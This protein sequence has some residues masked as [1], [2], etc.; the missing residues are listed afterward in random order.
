MNLKYKSLTFWKKEKKKHF[1]LY[2]P[3][4]YTLETCNAPCRVQCQRAWRIQHVLL[5]E[6]CSSTTQM[7][8]VLKRNYRILDRFHSMTRCDL[9]VCCTL[10]YLLGS[11]CCDVKDTM[12]SN[13]QQR[14]TWVIWKKGNRTSYSKDPFNGPKYSE[15]LSVHSCEKKRKI[16]RYDK[17]HHI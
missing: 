17:I 11:A 8:N 4:L 10:H 7:S 5:V 12:P 9:T 15:Q 3:V 2:A 16:R 14:N 1:F 13:I 6:S